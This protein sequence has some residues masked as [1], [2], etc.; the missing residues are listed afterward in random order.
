M[1][2]V[3]HRIGTGAMG[4]DVMESNRP[5]V[6]FH[7]LAG[8]LVAGL[9][10]IAAVAWAQSGEKPG[11]VSHTPVTAQTLPDDPG[12]SLTAVVVE[13][14]P[15]AASPSH[16]HAG[17]VF[18]YVLEGTVRSQ[19]NDGEVIEYHAGQYWIEPPGVKH[20]L[21]QN[22]SRTQP[23]RLLAVFVAPTG[24]QLTTYDQ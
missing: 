18:A 11:G 8:L 13:L 7:F 4:E 16:H 21:T 3:V 15:G 23:A 20:T 24:A 17:L 6:Y 22:P 19:I 5:S 12:R 9:L 14:A 10:G 1:G 2:P